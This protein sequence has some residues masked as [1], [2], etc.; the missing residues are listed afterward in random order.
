MILE[1]HMMILGCAVTT[2]PKPKGTFEQVGTNRTN[3][4]NSEKKEMNEGH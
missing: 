3:E 2:W 4:T 1:I